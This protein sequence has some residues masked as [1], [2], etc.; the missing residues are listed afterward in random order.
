MR[1]S[2]SEKSLGRPNEGTLNQSNTFMEKNNFPFSTREVEESYKRAEGQRRES[3]AAAPVSKSKSAAAA[4]VSKSK[5]AAVAR[6]THA[7]MTQKN[8]LS[9]ASAGI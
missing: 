2:S 1:V 5:S 6:G 7:W 9:Y 3:A 8:I 4:P